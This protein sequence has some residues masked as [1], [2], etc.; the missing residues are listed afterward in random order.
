VYLGAKDSAN[1]EV[2]DLKCGGPVEGRGSGHFGEGSKGGEYSRSGQV[3]ALQ[4]ENFSGY[5][6]EYVGTVIVPGCESLKREAHFRPVG[7]YL[8]G[9]R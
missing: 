3:F 7:R 6:P 9:Y 5:N 2:E 8:S 4:L 1:A